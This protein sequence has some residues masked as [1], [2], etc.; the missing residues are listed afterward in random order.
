MREQGKDSV[1]VLTNDAEQFATTWPDALPN[2]PCQYTPA[3]L[4]GFSGASFCT[5]QAAEYCKCTTA[6]S[7]FQDW[8]DVPRFGYPF[9]QTDVLCRGF[10]IYVLRSVGQMIGSTM[11]F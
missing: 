11:H 1:V 7:D 5:V 4:A 9:A 2:P 8:R 10:F 6:C 3:A